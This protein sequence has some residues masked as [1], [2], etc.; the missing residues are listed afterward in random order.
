[1]ISSLI[2]KHCQ[3]QLISKE[4]RAFLSV[5][6]YWASYTA[7]LSQGPTGSSLVHVRPSW[8]L[9]LNAAVHQGLGSGLPAT[10]CDMSAGWMGNGHAMVSFW[11][12]LTAA[13]WSNLKTTSSIKA[14]FILST[15]RP[16][17]KTKSLT[18]THVFPYP[19]VTYLSIAHA[20][21]AYFLPLQSAPCLS[22][23]D[24]SGLFHWQPLS[25]LFS[26]ASTFFFWQTGP[27]KAQSKEG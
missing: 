16:R 15:R 8:V 18:H 20:R 6:S 9:G 12:P 19:S 23:P 13:G 22:L 26:S 2:G 24:L 7:V 3:Q 1:M 27:P 5:K 21:P 14:L 10:K 25:N 4:I 11:E 17:Y